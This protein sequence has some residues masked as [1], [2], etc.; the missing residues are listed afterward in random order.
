MSY[1]RRV[2]LFIGSMLFIG[3]ILIVLFVLSAQERVSGTRWKLDLP[4]IP[5]E[6]LRGSQ[7]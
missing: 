6:E 4:D 5:F 1:S 2:A 7:Q 3:V